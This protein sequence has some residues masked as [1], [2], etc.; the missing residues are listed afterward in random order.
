[1]RKPADYV[2]VV[3]VR[4]FWKSWKQPTYFDYGSTT[5]NDVLYSIISQLRDA[6]YTVVGIGSDIGASNR[7]LQEN[8]EVSMGRTFIEPLVSAT[9]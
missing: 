7:T 6:G 2:Q 1:M 3:M 4:G 8:L 5:D 9:L